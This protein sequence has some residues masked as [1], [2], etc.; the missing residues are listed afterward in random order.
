MGS[1]RLRTYGCGGGILGVLLLLPPAVAVVGRM[2]LVRRLRSL[3]MMTM[4]GGAQEGR[5]ALWAIGS[6]QC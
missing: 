3:M 1:R 6:D 2:A 4:L 5:G